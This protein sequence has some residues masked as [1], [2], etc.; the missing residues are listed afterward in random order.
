MFAAVS[1][2]R[3]R[4]CAAVC[5]IV[6]GTAS[7]VGAMDERADLDFMLDN[8]T[9]L[10][11]LQARVQ[12]ER[13]LMEWT[14]QQTLKTLESK[15]N[16]ERELLR[17]AFDDL[18]KA[19]RAK[20][21]E[22][23]Q[24]L[25]AELE[26]YVLKYADTQASGDLYL[27]LAEL[28]F[29]EAN[30]QYIAAMEAYDA[31]V[32]E[33]YAGK[34]PDLPAMPAPDYKRAIELYREFISNYPTHRYLSEALYLYAFTLAESGN[35][36]EAVEVYEELLRRNPE[37]PLAP[38]VAFRIGE[39]YFLVG[40]LD[41][42]GRAY[43]HALRLKDETFYDKA[44]YKLAWTY[45]RQADYDR[46]LLGFVEMADYSAR[47]RQ[48]PTDMREESLQYIGIIFSE[49]GGLEA[50]KRFFTEIGGRP[51]E[52]EVVAKLGDIYYETADYANAKD[53]YEELFAR[54]PLDRNMPAIMDKITNCY[55]QLR[56]LGAVVEQKRR[57]AQAFGPGSAWYAKW[58]PEAPL[59]VQ[60][61]SETAENAAYTYAQFYHSQAQEATD[62][63]RRARDYAKA[64]EAYEAF[65]KQFP[66]STKI[67]ESVFNRAEIRYAQEQWKEAGE[68][69]A[70]VPEIVHNPTT[71]LFTDATWNMILS[72]RKAL[73]V[74]EQS[75]EGRR[76]IEAE[77]ADRRSREKS[78]EEAQA[79]A[80]AAAA[81]TQ[82]AA[83]TASAATPQ[84]T[85]KSKAAQDAQSKTL[86]TEA[87]EMIKANLYYVKLFPLGE[88]SPLIYYTTGDIFFRY[89]LYD[90]ARAQYKSFV[91][92]FPDNEF[93][94]DAIKQITRTYILE[95]KF[96]DLVTWGYAV[97]ESPLANREAVRDY[98]TTILSGAM[99]KEAQ[100]LEAKGRLN[101][102][103]EVYLRM[104]DR[105]PDSEF[106]DEALINAGVAYQ[107]QGNWDRS[108]EVF[109]RFYAQYPEHEF[110]PQALFQTAWNAERVLDFSAAVSRYIE[111]L[112]VYPKSKDT[113]D[114]LFNA[115]T[116]LAK[117]GDGIRAAKLY[118][119]YIARFPG[120]DD[121]ADN[122][123]FAAKAYYDAQD[124]VTAKQVF[125]RY[126]RHPDR[127]ERE[128]EA[129]YYLAQIAKAEGDDAR[130][131]KLQEQI[132]QAHTAYGE[133]GTVVD[134]VYAA[135]AAFRLAERV[136]ARYR[137]I[138]L[139]LPME[140]MARLLDEKAAQ[141]KLVE[142]A[143]SKVV[144][145]KDPFWSSAALHKIGEA[146]QEFANA[147]FDAPI[148][149]ELTEEEAEIYRFELE[150]QAF[151]IEEKAMQYWRRN[152]D[153]AIEL[154][155]SNEWVQLS[156]ERLIR[157]FPDVAN[158]K[159][160]ERHVDARNEFFY[161]FKA[162]D[163]PDPEVKIVG[164][165]VTYVDTDYRI[166]N[167]EER[168]RLAGLWTQRQ[169]RVLFD[170]GYGDPVLLQQGKS[171]DV[172][173]IKALWAE[174]YQ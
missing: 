10:E 51:Y 174:R 35:E 150:D 58:Q 31:A 48:A 83:A 74:Y 126:V 21:R 93:L 107:K 114:A 98:F 164:P 14:R 135:E 166:E 36:P 29:N 30:L 67:G 16:Q 69:Y 43:R 100:Q 5:A 49:R 105:F 37:G 95:E 132:I 12:A 101:D 117:L 27:R 44:L 33:F 141:L 80:A 127:T 165:K 151:P 70:R 99:F 153:L 133:K 109:L 147:L 85:A 143:Y 47:S 15:Y 89:G 62:A 57:Y 28:Y 152:L 8:R 60:E 121:E 82:A 106:V 112:D 136:D 125:E 34:R 52:D 167:L 4:I 108:T 50:L 23:H 115:A 59:Y 17:G 65:E 19:M 123:F 46:A 161:K 42:A 137:A 72:Y 156:R 128:V 91:E 120:E 53:V 146:Y 22:R 142:D 78:A 13:E 129:I 140:R 32:E 103:A 118:L 168:Y 87:I 86:P 25:I 41:L 40:E 97:F 144:L 7:A 155:I 84:S 6:I 111:L 172:G 119:L 139:Q 130:Y 102:A 131:F 76:R 159:A 2:G 92:R 61:V 94:L 173:P 26:S 145:F 54:R 66:Y 90:R 171:I 113:K 124:Y 20:G 163:V 158:V 96:G 122:L 104:I 110:A 1:L 170:I 169:R 63:A 116:I 71:E 56:Q 64:Y 68:L 45:Y 9:R 39:F 18:V 55:T 73:E 88:R 75:P 38:E 157:L 138:R 148:P 149:P 154:G 11:A 79:A 160:Q 134:P 77:E 24:A 81:A 162:S 3:L